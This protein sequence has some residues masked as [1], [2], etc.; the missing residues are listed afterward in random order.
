MKTNAGPLPRPDASNG[1][2]GQEVS[3]DGHVALWD[4]CRKP[5]SG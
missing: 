2:M 3:D 1:E 5:V 4:D